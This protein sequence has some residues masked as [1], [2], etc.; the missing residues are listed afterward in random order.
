MRAAIGIAV[1]RRH[2]PRL[3]LMTDERLGDSLWTALDN[4]PPGAGIVFR[5]YRT[6]LAERRRL[7]A[8]VQA[9]A[10]RR[11]LVLVR[12]GADRSEEPTSELQS[13]MRRSYADCC[14]TKKQIAC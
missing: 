12:A 6:P 11:G 7:F 2:P 10:D 13:L 14:L 1:P 3:W 8:G 5:H 4:L 9:I